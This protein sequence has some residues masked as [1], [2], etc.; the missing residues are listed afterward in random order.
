MSRTNHP[1]PSVDHVTPVESPKGRSATA[2]PTVE[3]G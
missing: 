2:P 3:P 1:P